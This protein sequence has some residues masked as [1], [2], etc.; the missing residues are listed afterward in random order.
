M[1]SEIELE[2]LTDYI[3]ELEAR[4]DFLTRER[5]LFKEGRE[6]LERSTQAEDP[7]RA[8][9]EGM[10]IGASSQMV[11]LT[12]AAALAHSVRSDWFRPTLRKGSKKPG[13]EGL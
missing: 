5:I 12:H 8:V 7:L 6:A 11:C 2:A 3:T 9:P 1:I 4:V 10:G 13:G